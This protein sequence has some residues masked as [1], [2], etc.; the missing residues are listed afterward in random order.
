MLADT[1]VMYSCHLV[2]ASKQAEFPGEKHPS[3]GGV[4]QYLLDPTNASS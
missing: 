1:S 2:F 3:K 4:V